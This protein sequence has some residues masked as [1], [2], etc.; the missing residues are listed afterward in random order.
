MTNSINKSKLFVSDGEAGEGM[1]DRQV[2][3]QQASDKVEINDL[4]MKLFRM[5]KIELNTP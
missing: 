5:V 2:I 3:T 1:L 4:K